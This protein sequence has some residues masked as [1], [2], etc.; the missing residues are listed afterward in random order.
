MPTNFDLPGGP[1]RV[2]VHNTGSKDITKV[3]IGIVKDPSGAYDHRDVTLNPPVSPGTG[4]TL[5]N[6][7]LAGPLKVV[8]ITLY[9]APDHATCCCDNQ[10]KL[11]DGVY[12]VVATLNA[13]DEV[14]PLWIRPF[15][16]PTRAFSC[17]CH[18]APEGHQ[19]GE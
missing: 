19:P 13:Q 17:G 6:D 10:P 9:R 12:E 4:E 14:D 5:V 15:P 11:K 16:R 1:G 8:C 3:K 2:K 18:E 7:N